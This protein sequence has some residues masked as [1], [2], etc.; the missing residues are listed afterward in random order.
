MKRSVIKLLS[1]VPVLFMMLGFMPTHA[2]EMTFTQTINGFT[3]TYREGMGVITGYSGNHKDLVVPVMGYSSN[4]GG[5]YPIMRIANGTTI[6]SKYAE[7]LTFGKSMDATTAFLEMGTD[8]FNLPNLKKIT[9]NASL[10]GMPEASPDWDLSDAFT[11]CVNVTE[12]IVS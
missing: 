9:F 11:D 6:S 10:S 1:L 12:I 8:V 2:M 7:T 5:Y 3:V 4:V